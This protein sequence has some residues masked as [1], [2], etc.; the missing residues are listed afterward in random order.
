MI[1]PSNNFW[2]FFKIFFEGSSYWESTL[3]QN[4]KEVRDVQSLRDI[5]HSAHSYM[6]RQFM[7]VLCNILWWTNLWVSFLIFSQV[8]VFIRNPRCLETHHQKVTAMMMDVPTMLTAQ[9]TRRK[10]TEVITITTMAIKERGPL[11]RILNQEEVSAIEYSSQFQPGK[12]CILLC[13]YFSR[14]LITW[15]A[16]HLKFLLTWMKAFPWICFA[17]F[18]Y[19][20]FKRLP[21][22]LTS[23][24]A[25]MMCQ[26]Y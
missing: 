11:G 2:F 6:W 20:H 25:N 13:D 19:W 1:F 12:C 3:R 22:E 14:I 17:L 9:V 18:E 24:V 8:V 21:F 23:L 10:V 15:I 5:F 4:V 7:M 26:I 16:I